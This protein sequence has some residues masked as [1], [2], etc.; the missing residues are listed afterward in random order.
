[1]TEL[2]PCRCGALPKCK[3][4]KVDYFSFAHS[5]TN[6]KYFIECPVCFYTDGN[7]YGTKAEAIE[8]WNRRAE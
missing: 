2:K 7:L 6:T 4:R 1:M 3:T 8:A 5:K